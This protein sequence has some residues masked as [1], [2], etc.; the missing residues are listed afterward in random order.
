VPISFMAAF[1]AIQTDGFPMD[2]QGR[3]PFDYLLKYLCTY[4]PNCVISA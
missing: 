3:I 1:F 2:E 4:F